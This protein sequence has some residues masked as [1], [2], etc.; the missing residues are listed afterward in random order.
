LDAIIRA[1]DDR[2]IA[3]LAGLIEYQQV[4]CTSTVEG[5]GG[6]PLCPQGVDDGAPLTVFPASGCHGYYTET[7]AVALGYFAQEGHGLYAAV[8]VE[9]QAEGFF[10]E[11]DHQ[12]IFHRDVN[13]NAWGFSLHVAGGRIVS[14]S[15][16]C[17]A[18]PADLVR[19]HEVIAGPW[20]EMVEPSA[21][22]DP[23]TG[24]E[25]VD[26]V[27]DAVR[28]YD[29][30][31]LLQ[32]ALTGMETLPLAACTETPQGVG[33]FP[34]DSKNG[35]AEGTEVR[36]FPVAYCEGA[37]ERDPAVP[38]AQFLNMVPELVAVVM[39]PVEPSR[40]ELYP[41]GAYWI[42]YDLGAPDSQMGVRLHLTETGALT[43]IW[44]GCGVEPDRLLL[45]EQGEPLPVILEAAR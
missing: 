41:N 36:V 2:D 17:G 20:P 26:D 18:A 31:T 9:D 15:D 13:G 8:A 6:P 28:G 32:S 11:A 45:D 37:L 40:S 34:C 14:M 1:V 24:V 33:D 39:A 29:L 43:A 23:Q 25:G 42:V 22:V 27:L 10:P 7:P 16:G 35:E 12:L 3:T 5:M 44:Y 21:S 19:E 4:A 30:N 38:L